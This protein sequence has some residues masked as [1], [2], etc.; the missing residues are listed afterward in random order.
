MPHVL[1]SCYRAC[2]S[3]GGRGACGSPR[4]PACGAPEAW[5]HREGWQLSAPRRR[6][7]RGTRIARPQDREVLSL[8]HRPPPWSIKDHM[9]AD[10]R[11]S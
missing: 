7:F 8:Q 1:R 4:H 9:L 3:P 10:P 11:D 2:Q 6:A 5:H